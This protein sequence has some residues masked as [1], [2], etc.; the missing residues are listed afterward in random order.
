MKFIELKKRVAEKR[1]ACYLLSGD[2]PFVID[3]AVKVFER[4][5]ELPEMNLIRLNAPTASDIVCAASVCPIMSPI[6]LTVVE[7][8][9]K[10][11]TDLKK[12]LLSPAPDSVILIVSPMPTK[13]LSAISD[14][15][16]VVDCSKQDAGVITSYIA[17]E[18]AAAGV[19]ITTAAANLLIDS[20]S[21][22]MT[23]ISVELSKLI[24][25]KS[26]GVIE[27]QDVEQLVNPDYE[28]KV[29]EL[30]DSIAAKNGD[31]AMRILDDMLSG[32]SAGVFGLV[33][34][35]FRKLLYVAVTPSDDEIKK[36]LGISDYPLKKLKAQ[37]KEY[38][39]KRLKRICDELHKADF[40]YKSGLITD[41]LAITTFAM[42]IVG[43]GR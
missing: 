12:Y 19:S 26:G 9:E 21:R 11:A 3:S 36:H 25:F 40:D 24:A 20:C 39:P 10:D 38:T 35:H 4:L 1:E 5:C 43:E 42:H 6:R 8:F 2:D 13:N 7:N 32:N 14:K 33:Y 37:A 28:Y 22:S 41:K 15:L 29:Y 27:S 34:S 23:R 17:R 16:T 31:K 18:C 30:G